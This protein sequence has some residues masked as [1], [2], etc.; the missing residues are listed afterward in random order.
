MCTFLRIFFCGFSTKGIEDSS[1]ILTIKNDQQIDKKSVNKTINLSND[2]ADNNLNN[3][4]RKNE[5]IMVNNYC[6]F[7]FWCHVVLNDEKLYFL[8][9]DINWK[10]SKKTTKNY[11]A[12]ESFKITKL[13]IIKICK[14]KYI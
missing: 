14:L 5:E 7:H 12:L 9:T 10:W 3:S 2:C 8:F 6:I 1:K 11:L 13:K 4:K